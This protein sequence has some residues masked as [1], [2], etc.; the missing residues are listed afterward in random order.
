MGQG[1]RLDIVE[2]KLRAGYEGK[3]RK[4]GKTD[5]TFRTDFGKG[6]V[7]M[8]KKEKEGIL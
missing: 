6:K 1:R 2:E 4:K 3:E 7:K 8:K 5:E